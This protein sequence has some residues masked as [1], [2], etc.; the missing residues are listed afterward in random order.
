MNLNQIKKGIGNPGLVQRYLEGTFRTPLLHLYR[1]IGK[2]YTPP[3]QTLGIEVNSICNMRCR[4]CDIGQQQ[5]DMQFSKNL[6]VG[7]ELSLDILTAVLDDIKKY[8]PYITINATEPLLYEPLPAVIKYCTDNGLV[9][10]VTTNGLLLQA[11]ARELVE[12][13]LTDLWVSIDGPGAIHDA[14][15]GV[16]HSFD[17]ALTGI[18]TVA[19]KKRKKRSVTPVVGIAYTISDYNYS[20][21]VKTADIFKKR[22]VDRIVYTHLN[23]IDTSMAEEHNKRYAHIFGEVTPSSVSGVNPK[24]V[25]TKVLAHQI[26]L[27][28]KKYP[29]F[30]RFLPDLEAEDIEPYYNDSLKF[31]KS[32]TCDM[33]WRYAQVCSNGDVIPTPR[34]FHLVMGNIYETPLTAIWKGTPFKKFRTA[35][36]TV[37]VTPACARC[38]SLFG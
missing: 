19:D 2:E 18:T 9:S 23:F 33:A 35:V 1:L 7:G 14:I 6:G 26:A 12:A 37:G 22:G 38:C 17:S 27:L 4:M 25:D 34:C 13:G 3:L 24:K 5:K 10:S 8:Y 28:K 30:V 21:L 36:H 16:P 32:S 20:H 31:V 15:R 11:R 29:D